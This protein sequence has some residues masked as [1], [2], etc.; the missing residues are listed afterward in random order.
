[1][2]HNSDP[3]VGVVTFELY[4]PES[5]SLKD[6]RSVLKSM[7]TRMRNTF[8]VSAAEIDENDRTQSA[9]IAVAVVSNSSRHASEVLQKVEAWI[10]SHYPEAQIVRTRVEI[11]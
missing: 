8:N 7:L 1:M 5:H 11:L 10:E 9:V 3:I 2:S 6:K 4:L